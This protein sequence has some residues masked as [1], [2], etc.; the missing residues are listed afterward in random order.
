MAMRRSLAQNLSFSALLEV[1]VLF[2]PAIPAYI[3]IWPNIQGVT[4]GADIS[5]GFYR[6]E[7]GRL[8]Q[9]RGRMTQN[10]RCVYYERSVSDDQYCYPMEWLVAN[11]WHSAFCS[12]GFYIVFYAEN[13]P[14]ITAAH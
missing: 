9:P 12:C 10:T 6:Y 3:W 13:D 8:I 7:L 14:A 2:L 1:A 4:N 5:Q 11:R